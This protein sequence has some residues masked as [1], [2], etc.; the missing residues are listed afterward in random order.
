MIPEAQTFYK[1]LEKQLAIECY[2]ELPIRRFFTSR[3]DLKRANRRINNPRYKGCF[4]TLLRPNESPVGIKDDFGSVAIERGSWVDVPLL[5]KALQQYFQTKHTYIESHFDV[6]QLTK[7][8]NEN[9]FWCYQTLK[10][11]KVIF[12]QGVHTLQNPYFS[13]LPI[14]PIKGDTLTLKLK[15]HSLPEGLYYK[16]RWLHALAT[17][18]HELQYR[19][20]ASYEVDNSNPNPSKN[21]QAELLQ[22]LKAMFGKKIAF[23]ILEHKSGIRPTCQFARPFIIQHPKYPSLFAINGLGSKGTATAPT[24][25]KALAHYLFEAKAIPSEFLLV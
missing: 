6:K 7:P 8:N 14:L 13:E 1:D 21:A 20:G 5:L 17:H 24:L 4:K 18:S 15:N 2:K 3:D 19:L 10:I 23:E 25:T 9:A 11:K 22:A 16:K 12:C